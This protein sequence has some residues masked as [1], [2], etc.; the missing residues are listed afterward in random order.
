MSSRAAPWLGVM[1]VY[2]LRRRAAYVWL[3][4]CVFSFRCGLR[5]LPAQDCG[6]LPPDRR[7][8]ECGSGVK[9]ARLGMR[10]PLCLLYLSIS[11]V[12]RCCPH[13]CV[14]H[15]TMELGEAAESGATS[16]LEQ[17]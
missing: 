13:H 6:N 15:I 5:D 7:N 8:P 12:E 14:V 2:A 11:S 9:T 1:I 10:G 16:E 3:F 17:V 4:S